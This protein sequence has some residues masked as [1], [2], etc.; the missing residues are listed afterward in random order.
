M[1]V[2]DSSN[3]APGHTDCKAKNLRS[4]CLTVAE[5]F[6][7]NNKKNIFFQKLPFLGVFPDFFNNGTL[8]RTGAS[9]ELSNTPI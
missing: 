3:E 2:F 7:K 5:I 4:L 6:L 9:F 8:Q 1:E